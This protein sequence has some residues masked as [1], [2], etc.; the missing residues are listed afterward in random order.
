MTQNLDLEIK[1]IKRTVVKGKQDRYI[2]FV[3]KGGNRQKFIDRLSHFKDF[4]LDLFEK[5]NGNTSNKI[6][7]VLKEHKLESRNCYIISENGDIDTKTLTI[8]DAIDE[9][10]GYRTGTI[11]VF[12]DVSMVFY[13][14]E[15]IKESYLSTPLVN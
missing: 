15:S 14:G 3:S 9:I 7:S 8:A 5:V 10:D 12:G 2:Q 11:L 4:N 1:L 13:E 6:I